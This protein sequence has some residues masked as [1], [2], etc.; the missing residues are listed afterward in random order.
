M[1]FVRINVFLMGGGQVDITNYFRIPENEIFVIFCRPLCKMSRH[2]RMNM[3]DISPF[4][5][6]WSVNVFIGNFRIWYISPYF[7]SDFWHFAPV[8]FGIHFH[9][10]PMS[11]CTDMIFDS[12]HSCMPVLWLHLLRN[13]RIADRAI[14]QNETPTSTLRKIDPIYSNKSSAAQT[15]GSVILWINRPLRAL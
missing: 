8:L 7:S 1:K 4:Y 5:K 6:D 3:Y 10:K 2:L 15:L 12:P 13:K 11:F 9:N 14:P